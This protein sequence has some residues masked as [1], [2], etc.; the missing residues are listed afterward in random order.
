MLRFL[1][2]LLRVGFVA[3]VGA[4]V[5]AKLLLESNAEPET[6]DIDLVAIFGGHAL[7]SVA[8]P[9][10]GG[11][12]IAMFGGA[13]VDLTDATPAPT[14]MRL[15]VS[16]A[17]GGLSLVVPEG[18]RVKFRGKAILGGYSDVTKTTADQEVP[19][20]S[21]TGSVVMGGIQATNES[22]IMENA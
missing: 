13:V 18:W 21:I 4:A 3:V 6:Q 20:V 1:F 12:L 2:K 19:T 14:E 10:Y 8:E 15:D 9:F 7:K 17:A 22:P 5:A 16:I 11:K